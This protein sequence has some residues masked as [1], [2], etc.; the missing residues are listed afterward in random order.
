MEGHIV[1]FVVKSS[2]DLDVILSHHTLTELSFVELGLEFSSE[3]TSGLELPLHMLV[4]LALQG[5]QDR[6][7]LSFFV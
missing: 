7:W 6:V 4:N 3:R 5:D 2:E 1:T